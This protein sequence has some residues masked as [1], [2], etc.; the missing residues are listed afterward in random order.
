MDQSSQPTRTTFEKML[1]AEQ[2]NKVSRM[3]ASP[4]ASYHFP[5][6]QSRPSTDIAQGRLSISSP[7]Q[8]PRSFQNIGRAMTTQ[9]QSVSIPV[10]EQ[11]NGSTKYIISSHGDV[12]P[13]QAEKEA[14]GDSDTSSICHSPGWDDITG[15]KRKKEKKEKEKEK[16]KKEKLKLEGAKLTKAP[17]RKR[18]SKV[19]QAMDRSASEPAIPIVKDRPPPVGFKKP[20]HH[21]RRGSIEFG[22]RSFINVKKAISTPWKSHT[23]TTPAAEIPPLPVSQSNHTNEG[24]IGGLKLRQS[25]EATTQEAIRKLTTAAAAGG[26]ADRLLAHD[27]DTVPGI[28]G[29]SSSTSISESMTRGASIYEE[30]IRTPQQWDAIYAQAALLA[31]APDDRIP[32]FKLVDDDTPIMER[33]IRKYR[34]S[35][36]PTSKFF[37]TDANFQGDASQDSARSS[38]TSEES[39]QAQQAPAATSPINSGITPIQQPEDSTRGRPTSY[40]QHSRQQSQDQAVKELNDE[41]PLP[42][43]VS[44]NKPESRGRSIFNRSRS[45]VRD[46]SALPPGTAGS[47]HSKDGESSNTGLIQDEA[48][49]Q[50]HPSQTT[51]SSTETSFTR[52]RKLS[53][54]TYNGTRGFRNSARAA[55][56]KGGVSADSGSESYQSSAEILMATSHR[57]Q[58]GKRAVMTDAASSKPTSP[59]KA[60]RVLGEDIPPTIARDFASPPR[61]P[62]RRNIAKQE[63]TGTSSSSSQRTKAMNRHQSGSFTDSS[64]E[65][66]TP[67]EFSNITTPTMSRPHSGKGY[68]PNMDEISARQRVSMSRSKNDLKQEACLMTGAVQSNDAAGSSR[69]DW[70]RTALPMEMNEDEDRTQTPTPDTDIPPVPQIPNGLSGLKLSISDP[71]QQQD[72]SFLPALKHQSLTPRP[73]E[74][75][76]EKLK[77]KKRATRSDSGTPNSSLSPPLSPPLPPT[78]KSEASPP[79]SPLPSQYLRNARLSLPHPVT[80]LSSQRPFSHSPHSSSIG[81]GLEPVAKMFVICCSCKYFHDMPSKIYECMVKP[82]NIVRD[83]NRGVSGVVSTAV[84]CPWCGHGMSTK[85][86]AGYAGVVYLTERLH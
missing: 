72:L 61:K 63:S 5:F 59:G 68:F 53:F 42:A 82:D 18:L 36:P 47:S 11:A 49:S 58:N 54:A 74:N 28:G 26:D 64:E 40:V 2:R 69:E 24:F 17:P 52:H 77:P 78:T 79:T 33:N 25:Q 80:K 46:T 73:Q 31:S 48:S 34:K 50:P 6:P 71:D 15:S 35:H 67:D 27:R 85:C 29:T 76:K 70:S 37:D 66:S 39:S 10:P 55:V 65:Y 16:K 30:S 57:P 75:E 4:Y 7:E 84:K 86:C 13:Q 44:P 23:P 32:D 8:R 83:V 43:G 51:E 20:E 60:A 56:S 12:V 3:Q 38:M 45:R 22:L 41:H 9:N 14:G 81:A 19:A 21:T 62:S 1:Q